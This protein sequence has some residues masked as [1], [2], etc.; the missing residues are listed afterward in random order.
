MSMVIMHMTKADR[1]DAAIARR[2]LKEVRRHPE[3]IVRGKQ[4][5]RR[6]RNMG[7]R[8]PLRSA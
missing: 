8:A 2:A 7:C 3:K 5:A 1:I 6:L 4:L